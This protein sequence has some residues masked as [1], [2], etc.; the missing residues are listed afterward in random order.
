MLKA[1]R[2][3]LPTSA[4]VKF[5]TAA[6]AA[7]GVGYLGSF[8]ATVINPS[9]LAE[10]P[11]DEPTVGALGSI[12]LLFL[13]F[14]SLV[15]APFAARVSYR[16]LAIAGSAAAAFGYAISAQSVAFG[17]MAAARVVMGIG[18]GI[19][20]VAVN[21]AV[22][23][24][25]DPDRRFAMIYTL[26]GVLAAIYVAGLP[27][28]LSR[29][30]YQGG[31]TICVL[32]CMVA[33]PFCLWLPRHADG[34]P[35]STR[36]QP[37]LLV[38][39]APPSALAVALVVGSIG[40]Y[41]IGEQALWAFAGEI[42]IRNVGIP[43]ESIGNM[44]AGM[45]IAGTLGGF[46]AWKL[47]ARFGRALPILIGS[48]MSALS[49]FGF[50]LTDDY[51]MMIASAVL[52]GF[53][54]YFISPYQISVAAAMDRTGRVAV[55]A[56]A[57]MNFGYAFGPGIGGAVIGYLGPRALLPLVVACVVLPLFML[58]PVAVAQDRAARLLL[59]ERA[60]EGSAETPRARPEEVAN[61]D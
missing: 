12:E 17:P 15:L 18:A 29:W 25:D 59:R 48:L 24:S 37:Q 16:G 54:F 5:Q 45:T 51:T 23:S 33:L 58:L 14:F 34:L 42:G 13:A 47:G 10:T 55:A 9:L 36:R 35:R 2:K 61:A 1:L 32:M 57:F 7:F 20:I 52:W 60:P 43:M 6:I 49:R 8:S 27:L 39:E 31:F 21:A 41:S 28:G 44:M 38:A 4:E 19:A 56:G 26:S 46:L 30:G 53:S 40:I 11:L 3:H 22:A 50:M